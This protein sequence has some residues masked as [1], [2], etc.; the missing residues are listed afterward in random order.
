MLSDKGVWPSLSRAFIKVYLFSRSDIKQPI[1][2]LAAAK[3]ERDRLWFFL[4]ILR[5]S[6]LDGDPLS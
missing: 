4:S 2:S 5:I 1:S 6:K 3:C